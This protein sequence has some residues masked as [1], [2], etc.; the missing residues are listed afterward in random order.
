MIG[1]EIDAV[2]IEGYQGAR[3]VESSGR[4]PTAATD[5]TDGCDP[6]YTSLMFQPIYCK[7]GRSVVQSRSGRGQGAWPARFNIE[8][9]VD[10]FRI[11]WIC[12]RAPRNPGD[13]STTE[14]LIFRQLSMAKIR[15]APLDHSCTHIGKIRAE[16]EFCVQVFCL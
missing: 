8:V 7:S 2:R 1:A 3:V 6:A 5:M 9:D 14:F 12:L 11:P 16:E 10:A 15:R 13:L 4:C